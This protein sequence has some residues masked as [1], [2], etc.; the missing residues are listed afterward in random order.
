MIEIGRYEDTPREERFCPFCPHVV[1]NESHFMFICPIYSS[2][3]TR[4]LSPITTSIPNF[5]FLPHDA[6]LQA[7]LTN[8]EQGIVKF[9]ATGMELRQFLV[10][11]PRVFS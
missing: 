2:L 3:R 9:I 7:L 4:Y 10:S 5:Q 6:K 1:E 11:K 8:I